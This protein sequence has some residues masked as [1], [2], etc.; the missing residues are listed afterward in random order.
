MSIALHIMQAY[1][2]HWSAAEFVLICVHFWTNQKFWIS[3]GR[4]KINLRPPKWTLSD[5]T[6]VV[7]LNRIRNE[8]V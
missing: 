3:A 8:E 7:Q 4:I 2:A 6:V 5:K 1:E